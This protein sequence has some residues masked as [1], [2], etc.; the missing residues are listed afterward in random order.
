M[1]GVRYPAFFP[2][3]ALAAGCSPAQARITELSTC[4]R[5]ALS[6]WPSSPGWGFH[7]TWQ[8]A[9]ASWEPLPQVKEAIA[10]WSSVLCRGEA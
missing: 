10:M 9:Q 6:V 1:A 7:L 4:L 3:E 2:T 5:S 8:K